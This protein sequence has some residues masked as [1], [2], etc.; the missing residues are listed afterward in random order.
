[1]TIL[2]A[3]IGTSDLAIEING[4]YFPVGFDREERNISQP[5][6]DSVEELAWQ[7]RLDEIKKMAQQEL[8]MVLG[9]RENPSFRELTHRLLLAYQQ[10]PEKWHSRLRPNRI[11]GVIQTAINTPFKVKDAYIFVTDQ[12]EKEADG[13]PNRGYPSDTIF[14]FEILAKWL[15]RE[16]PQLRLN[17]WV[18]PPEISAI[19]QDGLLQYY[20][21]FFQNAVPKNEFYLIS[22]KGGT[23][24]MQTALKFQAIA[25]AN[26]QQLFIDPILSVHNVL[27]GKISDC[28]LTS[29][30]QYFRTQK[31]QT[32]QLL[33]Q[34]RWD[35]DGAIHI[36][37]DWKNIL[38]FLRKYIVD[39]QL[40]WND[41][42]MARVRQSLK[43]CIH[44]FNLDIKTAQELV[45]HSSNLQLS[46][47]LVSQ[48][49]NYNR[50]LN[51]Y[52]QCR[53]YSELDQ[54]ANFLARMTSFYEETLFQ[55]NQ[56]LE[57]NK[58]FEGNI[59][60]WDLNTKVLRQEMGEDLWQEF[61]QLEG[62]YNAKLYPPNLKQNPVV[63]LM[64][65][66]IK[67]SFIEV[68][69]RFRKS[70]REA[71]LWQEML[72][73]LKSLDYWV[74][75][76]NNLI[77][78]IEGVSKQRMWELWH[79]RSEKD[80]LACPPN[81]ILQ[82]MTQIL[83]SGFGIIE[84]DYCKNFVGEQAKYYIYSEVRDWAI[85]QLVNHIMSDSI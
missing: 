67:R 82:V 41:D 38:K 19:N 43:L 39:E 7:L 46:P 31:Y 10:E 52:T 35:F 33:L 17:K 18:I 59:E 32:V 47:Q 2:L 9:E 21:H 37:E 70:H 40:A 16:I 27:A 28:Q 29:Y 60:K 64:N 15:E 49:S 79:S 13:T 11:F 66:Y 1:M 14:L 25:S 54:V 76:R 4:Y 68:L 63:Q 36:L 71:V 72:G 6:T 80:C 44:C 45:Q 42:L 78:S 12:P 61:K 50:L 51:L 34:Q 75:Q 58:Y 74:V 26:P 65:R 48:I 57:G 24:Q 73:L 5:V 3:N 69:V 84:E 85:A 62:G 22:I 81:K 83:K 23:P 56:R 8:G 77:H 20:Y 30:W 53:I 55:V